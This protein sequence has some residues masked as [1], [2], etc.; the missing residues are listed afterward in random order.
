MNECVLISWF[1]LS[2]KLC[3]IKKG[4]L[5]IN[6]NV[7]LFLEKWIKKQSGKN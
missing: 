2:Q 1:L 5:K 6:E 4:N 3:Q 7:L